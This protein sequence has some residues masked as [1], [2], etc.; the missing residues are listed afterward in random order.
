M[1]ELDLRLNAW[2]QATETLSPPPDA[3]AALHKAI[4]VEGAIGIKPAQS[5]VAGGVSVSKVT[6][7]IASIAIG[8]IVAG[9][10]FAWLRT[11]TVEPSPPATTAVSP[12]ASMPAPV[13]AMV[14]PAPVS[15]TSEAIV[16]CEPN[17]VGAFPEMIELLTGGPAVGME[18][19]IRPKVGTAAAPAPLT[20]SLKPSPAAATGVSPST[21]MSAPVPAVMP[22]T[23]VVP[24]SD[25]PVGCEPDVVGA[26]PEVLVIR[27]ADRA[28]PALGK[29]QPIDPRPSAPS[30]VPPAAPKR[31]NRESTPR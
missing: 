31:P 6:W 7:L 3:L 28:M 19:P 8:V 24:L 21:S 2:R 25:A 15:P 22:A 27:G 17:A 18:S 20:R 9:G 14:K 4:E 1:D 16:E 5:S 29:E 11:R 23:P 10:L 26:F 30:P 13:P 12:P